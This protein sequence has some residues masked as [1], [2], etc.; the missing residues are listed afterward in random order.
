MGMVLIHLT[1]IGGSVDKAVATAS[2]AA[3]ALCNSVAG[4]LSLGMDDEPKAVAK[5]TIFV[6]EHGMPDMISLYAFAETAYSLGSYHKLG[7]K[8]MTN[9]PESSFLPYSNYTGGATGGWR[10]AGVGI[11]LRL[12]W[13]FE[14]KP[15]MNSCF[16][17]GSTI[18]GGASLG[19]ASV[20]GDLN[21]SSNSQGVFR[22]TTSMGLGFSLSGARGYGSETYTAPIRKNR[23]E[24]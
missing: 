13:I 9:R 24:N 3:E 8:W 14:D 17:Y 6:A 20:S 19:G 23:L 18:A 5:T 1:D 2:W 10:V 4:V 7:A 11:G 15:P 12:G 16:G 21:L 22:M